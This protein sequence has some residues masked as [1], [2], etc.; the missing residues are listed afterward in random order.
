MFETKNMIIVNN[1]ANDKEKNISWE[2]YPC[3]NIETGER[4]KKNLGFYFDS[5]DDYVKNG[6]EVFPEF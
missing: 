5:W 6:A 1:V 3:I 4:M 2:D